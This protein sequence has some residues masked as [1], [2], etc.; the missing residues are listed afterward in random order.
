MAG[1]RAFTREEEARILGSFRACLRI[2]SEAPCHHDRLGCLPWPR[3]RY[4]LT[5]TAM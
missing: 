1:R 2:P 4:P 5:M 3:P